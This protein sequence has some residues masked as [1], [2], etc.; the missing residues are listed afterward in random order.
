MQGSYKI[1]WALAITLLYIS[2]T[3]VS[4]P[5]KQGQGNGG[6]ASVQVGADDCKYKSKDGPGG[7][8]VDIKCKGNKQARFAGNGPPPW[9][10]ANGYRQNHD[11]YRDYGLTAVPIDITTGRCNREV[12]GQVL[13]GAIGGLAGSQIG[14]GTGRLIAVAAG[15]LAGVI[16]GGEIG[17]SMDKADQL[18]FDQ[19][20]EHAPDG[21]KIV[22]NDNDTQY[23]VTPQE[24]VQEDGG[25]YCREYY[26]DANVQGRTQ[27]V[28]GT[29]CRQP[30][31]SWQ[32]VR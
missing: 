9:A 22:W 3:A 19:A 5:V 21:S 7:N 29:A 11:Q 32:L 27:Q 6:N 12:I 14:D 30:D 4:Q 26:M 20:L 31:G 25:R 1:S 18:C 16:I 17:K 28:V 10:P 2:G 23:A 24:T 8:K 13:G 15:T